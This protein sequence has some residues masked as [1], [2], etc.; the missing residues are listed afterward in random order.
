MVQR[1]SRWC[2]V[3][4]TIAARRYQRRSFRPAR[5]AGGLAALVTVRG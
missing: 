1:Q 5:E 4:M 3:A 2:L